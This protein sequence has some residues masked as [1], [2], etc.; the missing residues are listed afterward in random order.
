[1]SPLLLKVAGLFLPEAKELP[2]MMYQW[3]APFVLDDTAFRARFGAAPTALEPAVAA[4]IAWARA[5]YAAP[6]R[7]A[8]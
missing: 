7:A 5:T 3:R 4:T 2:E 6:S 1:M 8:A